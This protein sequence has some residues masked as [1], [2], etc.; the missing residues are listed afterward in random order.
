MGAKNGQDRLRKV[1]Q[2]CLQTT[3]TFLRDLQTSRGEIHACF[4]QIQTD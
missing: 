4:P 3:Q 2:I 1:L